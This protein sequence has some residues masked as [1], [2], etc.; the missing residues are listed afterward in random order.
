MCNCTSEVRC[1]ASPR[2][3]E[4]NSTKRPACAGLFLNVSTSAATVMPAMVA[5]ARTVA[6]ERLQ[7]EASDAGGDV[8]P[9]LALQADR[10]QRVGVGGTTDQEI[11]AAA[12]P[13][14]RIG[15]DAAVIAGELAAADPAVRRIHGPG[16][17]GLIGEA[18]IAAVAVH[19]GAVGFRPA[20]FALEHAFEARPRAHDEGDILATLAFTAAG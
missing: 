6:I 10:L 4:S 15:A 8:Q 14:R 11:A 7:L 12:D 20:A 18:E 3:D 16:Q 1:Y 2:N 19:G 17:P 9:G 5:P 13:D